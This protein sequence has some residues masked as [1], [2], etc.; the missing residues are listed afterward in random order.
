M[1]RV[2]TSA[3]GPKQKSSRKVKAQKTYARETPTINM[4]NPPRTLQQ[5]P[6]ILQNAMSASSDLNA[7]VVSWLYIRAVWLNVWVPTQEVSQAYAVPLAH[8]VVAVVHFS[9]FV[10]R[11][12]LPNARLMRD[13]NDVPP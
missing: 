5:L 11:A 10:L 4:L 3:N 13:R 7:V 9:C 2:R 8:V 6:S 1:T 12:A